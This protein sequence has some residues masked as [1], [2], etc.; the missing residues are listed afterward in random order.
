MI[1]LKKLFDFTIEE[2]DIEKEAEIVEGTC[3]FC[4]GKIKLIKDG[5]YLDKE[6]Y[7]VFC[8]RECYLKEIENEY[9]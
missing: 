2:K 3:S 5:Y 7:R 9:D 1:N 6:S 4:S 8:S